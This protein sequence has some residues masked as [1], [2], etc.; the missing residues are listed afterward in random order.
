VPSGWNRV[1]LD[2]IPVCRSRGTGRHKQTEP[3]DES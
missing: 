1:G 2:L 3:G